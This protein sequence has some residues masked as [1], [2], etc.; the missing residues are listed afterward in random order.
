MQLH[1]TPEQGWGQAEGFFRTLKGV[2]CCVV[3]CCVVLCCVLLLAHKMLQWH[4]AQEVLSG[5]KSWDPRTFRKLFGPLR[6]LTK[7]TQST[8]EGH[9]SHGRV[10]NA[11]ITSPSFLP[12]ISLSVSLPCMEAVLSISLLPAS[13]IG[14]IKP[15]YFIIIKVQKAVLG[16][17]ACV[18]AW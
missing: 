16:S 5:R 6:L 4:R 17:G 9:E 13:N 11:L 8:A 14:E 2:L 12:N 1:W 15:N 7:G 3:L 10:P 18:C